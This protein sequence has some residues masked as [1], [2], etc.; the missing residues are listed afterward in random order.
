MN[1]PGGAFIRDGEFMM[2]TI[3]S[4]LDSKSLL[5]FELLEEGLKIL[6]RI[7]NNERKKIEHSVIMAVTVLRHLVR[8]DA[9]S[10]T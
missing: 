9:Q 4:V 10:C 3:V 6:K 1:L 2:M 5:K 8:K 7:S